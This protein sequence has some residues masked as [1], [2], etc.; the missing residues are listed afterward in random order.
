MGSAPR[1]GR[2]SPWGR[3]AAPPAAR[4]TWPPPRRRPPSPSP[5]RPRRPATTRPRR[6]AACRRGT[7]RR[8]R[9]SA[10]RRRRGRSGGRWRPAGGRKAEPVNVATES[11]RAPARSPSVIGCAAS[12]PSARRK[13]IGPRPPT[14]PPSSAKPLTK[15]NPNAAAR[16]WAAPAKGMWSAMRSS[17]PPP[18]THARTAAISSGVNA[19]GVGSVQSSAMSFRSSRALAMTSTSTS[20]SAPAVRGTSDP[21]TTKP[22]ARRSRAK[23]R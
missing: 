21:E 4:R 5:P 23:L 2:S 19:E 9:D 6:C 17:A 10:R 8:C 13:I 15:S 14:S 18:S 20:A 22:S 16:S 12:D 1:G 11:T 3:P 7:S